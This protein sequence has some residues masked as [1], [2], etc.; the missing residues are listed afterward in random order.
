M[1]AGVRVTIAHGYGDDDS[2]SDERAL[3]SLGNLAYRY[4]E[5]FQLARLKNTHAKIL[6][7]D[8]SLIVTSFNWLSFRGDSD[9]TYR[10]EEGTLVSIPGRVDSQ[11]NRYLQMIE[12]QKVDPIPPSA[13]KSTPKASGE[14]VPSDV[15][16]E[17]EKIR[18]AG[19]VVAG[20]VARV[21]KGGLMVDVGVE[22][23]LPARQIDLVWVNDFEQY[24]GQTLDVM[25]IELDRRRKNVVLSR[26]A[27]LEQG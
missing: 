26:R 8:D 20:K 6:I 14:G 3:R 9:R 5:R 10:M 21:V 22:G 19:G 11:Y 15:W 24:V 13:A 4:P 7:F 1:K 18:I 23:F 2:G 16:S 25:I 17:L 12:E 27:V